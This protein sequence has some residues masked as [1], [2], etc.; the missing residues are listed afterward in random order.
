MARSRSSDNLF[1]SKFLH[2]PKVVSGHHEK[3][4]PPLDSLINYSTSQT[5]KAH[6]EL[7]LKTIQ[8][9]ITFAKDKKINYNQYDVSSFI[10]GYITDYCGINNYQNDLR[11]QLYNEGLAYLIKINSYLANNNIPEI[12]KITQ[13][14][15]L[16]KSINNVKCPPGIFN[17]ISAVVSELEASLGVEYVLLAKRIKLVEQ[18]VA[19]HLLPY[20]K[21]VDYYVGMETHIVQFIKNQYAADL[22][23]PVVK[24]YYARQAM[25]NGRIENEVQQKLSHCIKAEFSA[26]A[27]VKSIVNDFDLQGQSGLNFDNFISQIAVFGPQAATKFYTKAADILNA[28]DDETFLTSQALYIFYLEVFYRLVEQEYFSLENQCS[29]S[30]ENGQLHYIKDRSLIFAYIKIDDTNKP[31]LSACVSA[32]TSY[33][34][35]RKNGNFASF[36]YNLSEP[37][38]HEVLEAIHHY[39]QS[40][41]YKALSDEEQKQQNDFLFANIIQLLPYSDPQ[42]IFPLLS[43]PMAAKYYEH[44]KKQTW[45]LHYISND[46]VDKDN[47]SLLILAFL[48]NDSR[49]V[50]YILNDNSPLISKLVNQPD[51]NG[52]SPLFY[53]IKLGDPALITGLLRQGAK[54]NV[55]NGLGVNPL[56]HALNCLNLENYNTYTKIID[57]LIEKTIDEN[58]V[59]ALWFHAIKTENLCA[60]DYLLEKKVSPIVNNENGDTPLMLAIKTCKKKKNL[61]V[62]KLVE[63]KMLVNAKNS[64]TGMTA[65]MQAA[66]SGDTTIM[67]K[68][69]NQGA[70]IDVPDQNRRT[71]LMYAAEKGKFPAVQYLISWQANE[72]LRDLQQHNA[73]SLALENNR[74]EIVNYLRDQGSRTDRHENSMIVFLAQNGKLEQLKTLLQ[75]DLR[76]VSTIDHLKQ[77]P[78]QLKQGLFA[79]IENEQL[80]V[81]KYLIELV[82]LNA[83][84]LTPLMHAVDYKAKEI[85][86][87]L[88]KTKKVSINSVCKDDGMTALAYAVLSREKSTIQF[89]IASGANPDLSDLLRSA[90]TNKKWAFATAILESVD[91]GIQIQ[92][93]K[94][95]ANYNQLITLVAADKKL[96]I[97]TLLFK[98]NI[99]STLSLDLWN[100]LINESIDRKDWYLV[101]QLLQNAINLEDEERYHQY[102]Q[103]FFK[104]II[105]T[106][107]NELIE[108][109]ITKYPLIQIGNADQ[110]FGRDDQKQTL[111]MKAAQVGNEKA[112][113]YLLNRK[114]SVYYVDANKLT[115]L[116][117]A[118]KA[119]RWNVIRALL[120]KG[121]NPNV[122]DD[123][124][125]TPLMHAVK[126]GQIDIVKMLLQHK[127]NVYM[128]DKLGNTALFYAIGA[129]KNSAETSE[130]LCQRGVK[131]KSTAEIA[132]QNFD[133]APELIAWYKEKVLN[134]NSPLGY[135][136]Q[137]RDAVNLN[138]NHALKKLLPRVG[139][140]CPYKIGGEES[141]ISYALKKNKAGLIK[142]LMP[143]SLS[144][145]EWYNKMIE[146]RNAAIDKINTAL[147][148]DAPSNMRS[149]SDFIALENSYYSMFLDAQCSPKANDLFMT[150]L[151]GIFHVGYQAIANGQALE[152]E[153][154]PSLKKNKP[155]FTKSLMPEF[156]TSKP[157]YEEMIEFRNVAIQKINT[158]LSSSDAETDVRSRSDFVVLENLWYSILLD[159]KYSSSTSVT[160]INYF[161]GIFAHGYQTIA[162][163]Q[164]LSAE[165]ITSLEGF[166][167]PIK[168]KFSI[169]QFFRS[170][171]LAHTPFEETI[172][173]MNLF[174]NCKNP[175]M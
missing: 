2:V 91:E 131:Y 153:F 22:G 42:E 122:I 69:K 33:L 158:P 165:F 123:T 107:N 88:I 154:I 26:E 7:F 92:P 84:E 106:E 21:A 101:K 66:L 56:E 83:N 175:S 142:S 87:W 15:E 72:D 35:D 159:P 168:P 112:V 118:A 27:F 82:S 96:N 20:Q 146:S 157:W 62:D 151:S 8:D 52:N 114:A 80:E 120:K 6:R 43:M 32:M 13:V 60:I 115:A 68:L 163:G 65:L 152:V 149:R 90:I 59:T 109:A 86:E 1:T 95:M 111:L 127:A 73:L 170:K 143:T 75:E 9:L 147:S 130:L 77:Q 145:N 37:Q 50:D 34:L 46:T 12:L 173:A 126:A 61:I 39:Q 119:Q 36:I 116:Q 172:L 38:L 136:Y 51:C 71:A 28:D 169:L 156:I 74:D 63:N 16:L 102:Y 55:R 57:L 41:E 11:K 40:L 97:L 166:K 98:Q 108:L 29:I 64:A 19:E 4:I 132:L 138:D 78:V 100:N 24:D 155:A 99:K 121:S 139:N 10:S 81:V 67:E 129:E 23:F 44:V 89:L 133:T 14:T 94:I 171:P 135:A 25:M 93:Q 76:V 3:P 117:L 105:A 167:S 49:K 5:T 54:I 48:N 18:I 17:Q 113:S 161:L 164:P 45:G 31:F 137:L 162:K 140:M 128:K 104:K 110:Y 85:I 141:F 53:G 79:A 125:M 30:T 103:S 58:L 174:N 144:S 124:G 148:S 47:T 134:D 160:L 70:E 150:Y